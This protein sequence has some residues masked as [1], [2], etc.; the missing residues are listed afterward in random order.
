[1]GKTCLTFFLKEQ[2]E[3]WRKTVIQQPP[4]AKQQAS[5]I[6]EIRELQG[7]KK[8]KLA[9]T[10]IPLKKKAELNN[11]LSPTNQYF[12]PTFHF[13]N[14]QTKASYKLCFTNS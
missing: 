3:A 12:T 14:F 10:S 6:S 7:I 9:S 5:V 2:P 13:Q 8:V 11:A 1:M 4:P